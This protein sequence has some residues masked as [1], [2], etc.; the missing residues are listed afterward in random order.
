LLDQ[1][2]VTVTSS[3]GSLPEVDTSDDAFTLNVSDNDPGK[4]NLALNNVRASPSS[5]ARGN[6]LRT[7]RGRHEP[8]F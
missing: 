4:W 6:R 3:P 7:L 1:I 5:Q 8:R 2:V